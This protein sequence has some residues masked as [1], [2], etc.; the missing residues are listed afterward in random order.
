MSISNTYDNIVACEIP[1][2]KIFTGEFCHTFHYH[3]P[4]E[5]CGEILLEEH[6]H[7]TG[8]YLPPHIHCKYQ[9][10]NGEICNNVYL[11][12]HCRVCDRTDLHVHCEDCE[13]TKETNIRYESNIRYKHTHCT[14]CSDIVYSNSGFGCHCQFCKKD[15]KSSRNHVYCEH[16]E[17]CYDDIKN[18]NNKKTY[19]SYCK[20][21]NRCYNYL[22]KICETCNKCPVYHKHVCETET[23]GGVI[24]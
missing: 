13:E 7:D 24:D 5:N 10:P 16:C 23:T 11:H 17:K 20:N 2:C 12:L 22:H 3:C 19:H 1:D 4:V 9:L 18:F 21:H 6:S 8:S 15:I 14:V